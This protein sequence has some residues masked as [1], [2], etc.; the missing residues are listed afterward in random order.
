MKDTISK[1]F[2]YGI[3]IGVVALIG[4]WIFGDSDNKSGYSRDNDYSSAR[5]YEEY[6][7]YDCTD[8][9][10]QEEAQEFFEDEGGPGS[11]YHGLDR[12]KDGIA[13]ETLP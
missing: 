13:C 5:S 6:G 8:F 11:D 9:S 10:T 4:W 3:V 1:I 7:D 2:G 12:D